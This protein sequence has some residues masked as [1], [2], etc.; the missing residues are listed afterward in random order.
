MLFQ[1]YYEEN[2]MIDWKEYYI[3]YGKLKEYIN[4]IKNNKPDSEKIF[5]KELDKYWLNYYNFI[6]KKITETVEIENV[7][8]SI[9]VD[10]FKINEFVTLNQ[11]CLR[12]IIKKHDKNSNYSLYPAWKWKIKSNTFQ[13]LFPIIK[14]VSK[15]YPRNENVDNLINNSS[16]KRKSMKFWV[17]KK[18]I[19]P[20]MCHILPNLPVY[21]WDED[22]NDHIYQEISSVYFDNKELKTY[23]TRINKEENNKLIRI[24]WYGEL[25]NKVFL[26][27]K[28]HHDDWTGLE[29]SKDRISI[30]T[31]NVMPFIRRNIRLNND[32]ANEIQNCI[33]SDNL[34]PIIRTT[35]NRISFQL[36][37]TNDIR[38]SLD[39]KLNL[40]KEKVSHLD[41][42]TDNED[43]LDEDIKRFKYS[44]LEI[45]LANNSIEHPPEWIN[46]LINSNLIISQPNFSKYIHGCYSFYNDKINIRPSWIN[47]DTIID[48]IDNV[49]ESGENNHIVKNNCCFSIFSKQ[50]KIAT[51]I[52][53]EPKTFFANERTYLQW[54]NSGILVASIGT[55]LTSYENAPII[56]FLL[57]GVSFCILIY[58]LLLYNKRNNLLLNR[59]GKGYHDTY[60]PPI[61]TLFVMLAFTLSLFLKV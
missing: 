37:N 13:K 40:I 21:V 29:S 18:N 3:D 53:I 12:K 7:D 44:V 56:G 9:L 20:V 17:E 2:I 34:Y 19:I 15:L 23:N 47:D 48:I 25:P 41:W 27:R 31:K 14:K 11:E 33:H 59:V 4:N 49:S 22:I 58:A 24:R 5:S 26:E 35:Y 46:S 39:L 6:D 16:F 54:F 61:L 30:E 43:I 45:K 36:K 8:K 32:L 10:I 52:K 60:G 55:A 1:K 50:E 38:I 51:A 57:V 28:V 42:F